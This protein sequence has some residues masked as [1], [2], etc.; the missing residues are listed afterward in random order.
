MDIQEIKKLIDLMV[1]S[2]LQQ[3]E[4]REGEQ[5]IS[6]TRRIATSAPAPLTSPAVST[7]PSQPQPSGRLETSPMIGVFY[8]A[9]APGEAPFVSVGQRIQAGDV[10]GIIEAM[11]IMNPIEATMDGEVLEVLARNGTVVEFGQPL[12]RLG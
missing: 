8:A 2:D 4:V 1:E 10:I 11:K 5:T 6:L 3:L 9:P 7:T 12:I